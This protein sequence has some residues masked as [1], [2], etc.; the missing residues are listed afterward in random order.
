VERRFALAELKS[1]KL[2]ERSEF[3]TY[4]GGFVAIMKS[5]RALSPAANHFLDWL[6]GAF[7]RE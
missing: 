1:G 7:M 3:L 2:V 4:E 6:R 5:G